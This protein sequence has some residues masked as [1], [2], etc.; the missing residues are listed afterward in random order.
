MRNKYNYLLKTI[1]DCFFYFTKMPGNLPKKQKNPDVA[2]KPKMLFIYA[3]CAFMDILFSASAI[4]LFII[5]W[6]FKRL[7]FSVIS[8]L[9]RFTLRV[10]FLKFIPKMKIY[11]FYADKPDFSN[12]ATGSIYIANHVSWLDPLFMLS[13]VPRAGIV[14]KSK[15]VRHSIALLV[16]IFDFIPVSESGIAATSDAF[17]KSKKILEDGKNLIIFPEGKR[18]YSGRLGD[19]KKLAFK[20]SK[21]TGAKIVCSGF[22]YDRI[23]YGKSGNSFCPFENNIVVFKTF[24]ILD[25][26]DFDD[27][28]SM[29]FAA[30]QKTF[31]GLSEI[32]RNLSQEKS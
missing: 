27:S 20:L 24:G 21:E 5:L 22:Y 31:R 32:K 23:I 28:Q 9:L 1:C 12:A 30:Y 8:N 29:A 17:S 6:P 19:Y 10:F 14:L 26:R 15:Y 4:F 16:K 25:P 11:E 7:R 3:V 2:S 13:M 18:S